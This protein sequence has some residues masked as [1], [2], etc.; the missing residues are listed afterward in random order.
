MAAFAIAVSYSFLELGW[1]YP[2][3]V[4]GGFLIGDRVDAAGNRR[5][6]VCTKQRRRA[7]GADAL[8]SGSR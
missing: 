2:S 7:G 8:R 4:L 5:A 3:D 1:H 6:G